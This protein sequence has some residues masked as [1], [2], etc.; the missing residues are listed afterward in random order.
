MP[1][2]DLGAGPGAYTAAHGRSPW[3]WEQFLWRKLIN[4]PLS[5][6]GSQ[7][8]RAWVSRGSWGWLGRLGVRGVGSDAV[9][10]VEGGDAGA[11]VFVVLFKAADGVA[12]A[13]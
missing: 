12:L 6:L 4:A 8:L 1:F 9:A 13:F 3:P 2:V 11:G 7:Q 5:V 10:L